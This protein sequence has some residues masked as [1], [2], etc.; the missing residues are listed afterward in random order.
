MATEMGCKRLRAVVP[1]VLAD[2]AVHHQKR[3]G[4]VTVD[5]MALAR[6]RCPAKGRTNL[7][8]KDD[9]FTLLGIPAEK[10]EEIKSKFQ[11]RL[12]QSSRTQW[13]I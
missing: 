5:W 7:E 3:A 10:K 6:V 8:W 9:V 1:E 12:G 2:R 4:I 11:A 13:S